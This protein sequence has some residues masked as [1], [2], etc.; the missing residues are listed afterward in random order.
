MQLLYF[1]CSSNR[2]SPLPA[3][4]V[5]FQHPLVHPSTHRSK[6]VRLL[7]H[8]NT[9]LPPGADTGKRVFGRETTR[10]PLCFTPVTAV[11]L[12][13]AQCLENTT[14]ESNTAALN[15]LLTVPFIFPVKFHHKHLLHK[16]LLGPTRAPSTQF[17]LFP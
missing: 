8:R 14:V 16:L 3:D 2:P 10:H 7:T 15:C 12:S 11:S 17:G 9:A 5:Q 13:K 1:K 4:P 6:Q